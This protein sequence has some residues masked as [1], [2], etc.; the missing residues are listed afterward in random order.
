MEA[1]KIQLHIHKVIIN[2]YLILYPFIFMRQ[3]N[4]LRFGIYMKLL[5]NISNMFLHSQ[6]TK[7]KLGGDAFGIPAVDGMF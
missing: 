4:D 1:E 5:V 6:Y 2:I 3:C 7:F